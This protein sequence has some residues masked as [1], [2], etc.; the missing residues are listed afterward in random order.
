VFAL[1]AWA[2]TSILATRAKTGRKLRWIILVL[3]LPVAGLI[4]W[5]LRGRQRL[6]GER[7]G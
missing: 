3:L 6:S 4:L 2:I 7:Y 5:H 1:D